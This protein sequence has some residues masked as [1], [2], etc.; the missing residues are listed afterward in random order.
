MVTPTTYFRGLDTQPHHLCLRLNTTNA[1]YVM[2]LC[3]LIV[4]VTPKLY[5]VRHHRSVQ[6]PANRK[7][8]C[9]LF[10]GIVDHNLRRHVLA[11]RL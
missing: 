4:S 10:R 7:S 8:P 11:V 1:D 9:S 2:H 3:D 6:W 5:I